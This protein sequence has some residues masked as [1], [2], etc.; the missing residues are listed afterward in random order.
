[1]C[2]SMVSLGKL[3]VLVALGGIVTAGCTSSTEIEGRLPDGRGYRV[4]SSPGLVDEEPEGV[5]AAIVINF[6]RSDVRFDGMP[7]PRPCTPVLGIATFSRVGRHEPAY[8]NQV[9]TASSGEWTMTIGVYQHIVDVWGDDIGAM[10]LENINPIEADNGLPAFHLSGPL[11]W[12]TDHEI[13]LQMEV[14]YP[15]FVVRRGSSRRT[16]GAAPAVPS[17]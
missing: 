2:S 11:R 12:A 9:Y 14:S 8:A 4:S 6:D 1:M 10:L 7:C 15:D 5:S 3:L 17:N 16:S 13:P